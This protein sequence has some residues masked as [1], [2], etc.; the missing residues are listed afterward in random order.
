MEVS[1]GKGKKITLDVKILKPCYASTKAALT[2]RVIPKYLTTDEIYCTGHSFY[3]QPWIGNLRGILA[4]CRWSMNSG[5]GRKGERDGVKSWQMRDSTGRL[6][7]KSVESSQGSLSLC[8]P[9]SEPAWDYL[10]G[11]VMVLGSS[12]LKSE[13]FS[14]FI[15]RYGCTM[16]TS[17]TA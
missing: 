9:V 10:R 7:G 6:T 17:S 12:C 4:I 14:Y 2:V 8:P 13:V 3:Q 5:C 15:N 16:N 11:P 1:W